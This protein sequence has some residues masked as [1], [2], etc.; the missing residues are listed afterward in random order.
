MRTIV[1][2]EEKVISFVNH[3]ISLL[4]LDSV[5]VEEAVQRQ[6]A[7]WNFEHLDC[8]PLMIGSPPPMT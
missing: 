4:K 1:A 5:R 7:A 6:S 2:K 3:W 8:I